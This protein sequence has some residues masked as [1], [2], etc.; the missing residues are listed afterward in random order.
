MLELAPGEHGHPVAQPRPCGGPQG[1]V[2]HLSSCRAGMPGVQLLLGPRQEQWALGMWLLCLPGLQHCSRSH[3]R[4]KT[5]F[6]SSGCLL[7]SFSQGQLQPE[8]HGASY[9]SRGVGSSLGQQG[10]WGLAV[11][12]G[13]LHSL[14]GLPA[15]L[16]GE[17]PPVPSPAAQGWPS[18]PSPCCFTPMCW[19]D[20]AQ[21]GSDHLLPYPTPPLPQRCSRLHLYGVGGKSRRQLRGG[22]RG[23]QGAAATLPPAPPSKSS[24]AGRKRLA[25]GSLS[26]LLSGSPATATCCPPGGRLLLPG[27]STAPQCPGGLPEPQTS[28]NWHLRNPGRGRSRLLRPAQGAGVWPGMAVVR[29]RRPRWAGRGVTGLLTSCKKVFLN[30]TE[31]SV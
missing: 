5:D 2:L 28:Q 25:T 3:H 11:C 14:V 9:P 18:P 27:P 29:C 6:F 23:S 8:P 22:P 17:C 30:T 15:A 13:A 24:P 12:R 20:D 10:T 31:S 26:A 1:L 21:R 7:A 4:N 16:C 19:R